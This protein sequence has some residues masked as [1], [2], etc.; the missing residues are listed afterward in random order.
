M[1][2]TD[3]KVLNILF[4]N[5]NMNRKEVW[6]LEV[7][8]NLDIS[9]ISLTPGMINVLGESLYRIQNDHLIRKTDVRMFLLE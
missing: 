1:V 8:K 3:K 2:Q 4:N 5:K 6:S 7:I 9:E